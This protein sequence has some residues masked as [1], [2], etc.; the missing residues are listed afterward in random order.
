M[1]LPYALLRGLKRLGTSAGVVDGGAGRPATSFDKLLA[2]ALALMGHIKKQTNQPR[3]H[4][5]PPG[6]GGLIANAAVLLAGKVPVN[7]NFTAGD[8]AVASC[9]NRQVWTGSS[10]RIR[11]CGKCRVLP[12]LPT[13]S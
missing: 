13:N 2:A 10:R 8:K 9:I 3:R 7:L 4:P 6:I 11:L 12:G 5:P 1:S